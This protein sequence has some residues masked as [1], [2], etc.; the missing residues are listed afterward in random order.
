[1]EQFGA[2]AAKRISVSLLLKTAS[3]GRQRILL[4][5]KRRRFKIQMNV[6]VCFYNFAIKPPDEL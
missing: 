6:L 2:F 4:L 5:M 3:R 1:L